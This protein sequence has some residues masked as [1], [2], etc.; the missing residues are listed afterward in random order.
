MNLKKISVIVTCRD[1]QGRIEHC[2]DS[3][4]GFGEC[5]VVD[6]FS[7]DNTVALARAR[8]AMVYQRPYT[9]AA[10][11]KNWALDIAANDWVLILDADEVLTP[12]LRSEIIDLQ[13]AACGYWIRRRSEYLGRVIRGCGWQRDRVLRLFDRTR[14]RYD[15]VEVHEEVVLDGPAGELRNPLFHHP[16]RDVSHHMEKINEYS[17]RGA[18]DFAARGGR[19]P[20]V[21]MVV[22]PPMRFVRMYLVQAGFRDGWQGLVL[23][24]LSMYSVFLKYAKAWELRWQRDE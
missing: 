21:R 4:R 9:S 20:G 16:Y 10:Q 15:A 12:E 19:M 11:Q 3:T 1:E 13:P 17:S 8:G 22:R 23:C 6:S 7:G 2:L 24:L 14:G 5:I 18:R